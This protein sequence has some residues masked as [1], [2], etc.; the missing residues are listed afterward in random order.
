MNTPI[1]VSSMMKLARLRREENWPMVHNEGRGAL[2]TACRTPV[3]L[4]YQEPHARGLRL[5]RH[6]RIPRR[7]ATNTKTETE[8]ITSDVRMYA[9]VEKEMPRP[10]ASAM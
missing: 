8:A 2:W 10:V 5:P 3:T 7:V 1:S 9:A 4:V 6:H